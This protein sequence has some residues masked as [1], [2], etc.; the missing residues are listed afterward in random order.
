MNLQ[1]EI[2]NEFKISPLEDILLKKIKLSLNGKF[3]NYEF[4][5]FK[6]TVDPCCVR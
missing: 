5:K 6:E 1:N 2:Y 3:V 4:Y